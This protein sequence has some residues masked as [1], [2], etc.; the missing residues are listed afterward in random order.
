M[1]QGYERAWSGNR[2]KDSLFWGSRSNFFWGEMS[3]WDGISTQRSMSWNHYMH[4][5]EV[6]EGED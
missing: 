4:A 5:I 1:G 6:G 2:E 3:Y